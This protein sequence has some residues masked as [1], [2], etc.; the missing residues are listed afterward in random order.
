MSSIH[1]YIPMLIIIVQIKAKK[2]SS[3]E[4]Q[5]RKIDCSRPE[6]EGTH[7]QPLPQKGYARKAMS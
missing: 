6:S 5:P 2:Q 7:C 3:Y 4:V 1:T